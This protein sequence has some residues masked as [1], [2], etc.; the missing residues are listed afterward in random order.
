M[1]SKW[2]VS[3]TAVLALSV[4]LGLNSKQDVAKPRLLGPS[5]NLVDGS[6][7]PPTILPPAARVLGEQSATSGRRYAAAATDKASEW[8]KSGT[9]SGRRYA[10]RQRRYSYIRSSVNGELFQSAGTPT[11]PPRSL[12]GSYGGKLVAEKGKAIAAFPPF[13]MLGYLGFFLHEVVHTEFVACGCHAG[14]PYF[15]T[16]PGCWMV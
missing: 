4:W 5:L 1:Y 11:A 15:D 6:H 9:A 12:A 10:G 3:F 2:E 7:P 8:G 14:K 13:S 16:R